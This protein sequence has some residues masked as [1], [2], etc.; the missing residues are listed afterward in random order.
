MFWLED[1]TTSL[2]LGNNITLHGISDSSAT[3]LI[4]YGGTLTMENGSKVTGHVTSQG[5]GAIS[6][7][8]TDAR[9]VMNGGSV[10]G[11]TST[12]TATSTASGISS[13]GNS[14]V[15]LNGGSIS[16]NSPVDIYI[17]ATSTLNL[18]GN[19]QIGV[20]R[21]AANATNNATFNLG[22]FNGTVGM[23]H[24]RSNIAAMNTAISYW[25][26]KQ[27]IRAATG[28]TL[29][30]EDMAKFPLGNFYSSTVG[31][32]QPIIDTHIIGTV[33][34][35]LGKLVLNP[36][37]AP[38]AVNDGTV[39][40]GY[41]DL[42]AAFAAIG[43]QAGNFT[44]TLRANQT[45]T[46][47]RLI[48]TPAQNITII[49]AGGIRTSNGS[50]IAADT[51]LF[52]ISTATASLTLGENITIQGR[53]VEGT[54]AVVNNT[55]GT[56][57]MLPGSKI[58]GHQSSSGLV[59]AVNMIG[60][61][62]VFEMSGGSIDNNNTTVIETTT[63]ASGGVYFVNG[64]FKM[65][66]GSI[67]G[68]THRG[69]A[70]DVY[71]GPNSAANLSNSSFEISGSANIGALKLYADTTYAA[72]VTIGT[73]WTG[74]ITKLN[75][76]ANIGAIASV[77]SYWNNK[78]VFNNI[79][80]AQ[81]ERIGIGEF[82]STTNLR[83]AISD[84]HYIGR[85]GND[86]G[87]LMAWLY[88]IGGTGPAGGIVFYR[89]PNGFTVQG[90]T[91]TTGTFATYTAYYLEAAPENESGNTTQW[92]ANGTLIAGV[93]TFTSVGQNNILTIGVGRK[94][95]QTIV[96][97]LGTSETGRA[98]QVCAS[99]SVIVG[100]IVFNDWFLPSLG[101]LNEFYKLKGQAG[102][103]Q[104]GIPTTGNFWSSSQRNNIDAW[105]QYFGSGGQGD[106][107]AKD[108][109]YYVRAVRAF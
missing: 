89:D 45:M 55:N 49:G 66:G 73:G 47:N 69:E 22:M 79:T 58:T 81:V 39:V 35:D 19:T 3:L 48:N 100:G 102:V 91:G 5:N 13:I 24:L 63:S 104:T 103:P 21:F 70:S 77:R 18:S 4:V 51:N 32:S 65:S 8:S 54:G 108:Y 75:L 33:A 106:Y 43:T 78:Q 86:L 16:G 84:M 25:E 36:A 53:T 60:A 92:G 74:T 87:K 20:L 107:L 88:A 72:D 7:N 44:V 29:I 59:A 97:H 94:D 27:V 50:N 67:T 15:T 14:T 40:K 80:A 2:T 6:V 105:G 30:A 95:T 37:T 61:S 38:V 12:N 82:I 109:S 96:N 68:N 64:T 62:S 9:F 11:N 56:F 10:I 71:F 90:Y 93:T 17:D 26:G 23:L 85:T 42:T 57:R 46:A 1:T 31:E 52:S 28:Y 98:A 34:P 41:A 76:R 99:R 101:E 83:S